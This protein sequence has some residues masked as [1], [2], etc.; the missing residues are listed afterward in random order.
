MKCKICVICF[1]PMKP[2]SKKRSLRKDA[3]TCSPA[4]RVIKW[5]E[6]K[7]KTLARAK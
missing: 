5:A 2:K 3:E 6:K 1:K 4:C 7:Q